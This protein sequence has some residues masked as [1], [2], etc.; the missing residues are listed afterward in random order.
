MN[1]SLSNNQVC[2]LDDLSPQIKA[3]T[4]IVSVPIADD[5]AGVGELA[6]EMK[7][8]LDSPF[9]EDEAVL[10]EVN[11][12]GGSSAQN[13]KVDIKEEKRPI[14]RSLIVDFESEDEDDFVP[15]YKIHKAGDE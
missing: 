13:L 12:A 10:C 4:K 3:T 14:K 6:E 1:F 9:N 5:V 11:D 8:L 2:G 15:A 7:V